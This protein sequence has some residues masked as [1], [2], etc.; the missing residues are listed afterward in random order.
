MASTDGFAA[1]SLRATAA[2]DSGVPAGEA[3]VAPLA[4][5]PIPPP[6]PVTVIAGWEVSAVR[7]TGNLAL[8]DCTPL[9]KVLIRAPASGL[10]AAE[11]VVP[12]GRSA[13]D[14]AG[15]L[16]V[17]SGPGE[18]LLLAAAGQGSAVA[19]R[20][21]GL[22][23]RAPA[24]HVSVVDL[25]HGRALMRLTGTAAAGMLARA[26]GIDLSDRFTP[27]GAAFRS[28]VAAVATDVIRD[29][30]AGVRSYLLHCERSSGRY[31]FDALVAAGHD[32]GIEI[33]GFRAP[34][35]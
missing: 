21:E 25:T 34:G 20:L 7:A 28:A 13:R 32:F 18:W 12:F 24:E 10:V 31:L 4:R 5:S 11:L 22:A 35:I 17:G 29:D 19:A 16:V 14:E 3:G 9:A 15:A 2:G 26:C 30:V 1:E 6:E 27:D 23:G 33:D 8:T